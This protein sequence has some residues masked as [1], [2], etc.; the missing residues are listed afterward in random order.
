MTLLLGI[1]NFLIGALNI[2]KRTWRNLS[3]YCRP[4]VI[5]VIKSNR[6]T[7]FATECRIDAYFI[8]VAV[9]TALPVIWKHIL[10]FICCLIF[11][12]HVIDFM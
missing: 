6:R 3:R 10:M 5:T 8:Y 1:D 2:N 11:M 4:I 7:L 9:Q 12:T